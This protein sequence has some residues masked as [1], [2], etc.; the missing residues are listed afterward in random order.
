MKEGGRY[1]NRISLQVLQSKSSIVGGGRGGVKAGGDQIV[2]SALK[3][4]QHQNI[5]V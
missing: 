2:G 1:L 3:T 5:W 4:V